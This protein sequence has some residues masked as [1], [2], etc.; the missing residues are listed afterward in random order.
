MEGRGK[1]SNFIHQMRSFSN[2][3]LN[4]HTQLHLMVDSISYFCS[5]FIPVLYFFSTFAR[6]FIIVG[7][8]NI[9]DVSGLVLLLIPSCSQLGGG[10]N[11]DN[12]PDETGIVQERL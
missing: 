9:A 2:I 4:L 1:D 12:P 6:T 11:E 5:N 7:N 3:I 10:K 8:Y